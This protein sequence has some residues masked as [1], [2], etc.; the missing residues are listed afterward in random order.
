MSFRGFRA[1]QRKSKEIK[2]QKA[3]GSFG[4]VCSFVCWKY[5]KWKNALQ[6]KNKAKM[7]K[8]QQ[9]SRRFVPIQVSRSAGSAKETLLGTESR[10]F[11]SIE[12]PQSR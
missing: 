12:W 8:S 10:Q 4:F 3:R 6:F 5:F 1:K 2:I 9:S 7:L 11:H